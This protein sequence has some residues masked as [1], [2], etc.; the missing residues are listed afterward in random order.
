MNMLTNK[1]RLF[2]GVFAV[3]C[4]PYFDAAGQ[5]KLL[6]QDFED[7]TPGGR[8]DGW[9]LTWGEMGNDTLA[10][11]SLQAATGKQSLLVDRTVGTSATHYGVATDVPDISDGWAKLSFCVYVD[12]KGDDAQFGFLVRGA[13]PSPGENEYIANVAFG[14]RAGGRNVTISNNNVKQILGAYDPQHWYRV[15]LW[16]PTVG[17]GQT[18]FFGMLE[19]AEADGKWTKMES[20]QSVPAS[21]PK[22][23]YWRF[24]FNT[25]PNKRDYEVFLDNVSWEQTDLPPTQ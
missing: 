15:T 4:L 6:F 20:L 18:E 9:R 21:A 16:L 8:P 14:S 23:H 7:Q 22:R 19:S 17:G 11:S 10:I 25:T 2:L 12:G 24:E 3:L 13:S 5:E 1:L